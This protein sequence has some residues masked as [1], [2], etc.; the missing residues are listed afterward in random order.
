EVFKINN[1]NYRHGLKAVVMEILVNRLSSGLN[2]T[3]SPVLEAS[4]RNYFLNASFGSEYSDQGIDGAVTTWSYNESGST[5]LGNVTK[6]HQTSTILS[7]QTI[8]VLSIM[9][10]IVF[11]LA[12]VGNISVV[13][14]VAKDKSLHTA[15]NFFLVNM[16]IADIL[17]AIFCLP[18]TLL[19]KIFTSKLCFSHLSVFHGSQ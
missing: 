12:L 18:L 4:E 15:T 3:V 7:L 14:V 10:S 11:V 16:A 13:T 2:A 9:Y 5:D 17:I 1:Q 8:V 6:R 19:S